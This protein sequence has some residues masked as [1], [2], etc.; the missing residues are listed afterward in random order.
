[1]CRTSARGPLPAL[2]VVVGILLSTNTAVAGGFDL[3][4]DECAA[5]SGTAARTSSCRSDVGA[6]VAVASFMV[7]QDMP[8]FVGIE[9]TIEVRAEGATLPDWW[10]FFHPG[11]C[12]QSAL[13]ASFDFMRFAGCVD[14]WEGQALGG[15]AGYHT[16]ATSASHSGGLPNVARIVLGAAVANPIGLRAGQEYYAFQIVISNARTT[17]GTCAGCASPVCLTLLELRAVAINGDVE[18]LTAPMHS[19]RISWQGAA[20]CE[21]SVQNRS[22]GH[23]KNIYR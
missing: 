13:S 14:P 5:A 18:R 8:E 15:L 12:R 21:A 11:A 4:W 6:N 23:V 10:S 22:W 19:E 9:A 3:A 20:S 7:S 17:S 1:M 16:L 2:A